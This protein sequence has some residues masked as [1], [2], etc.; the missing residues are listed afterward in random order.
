MNSAEKH[1]AILERMDGMIRRGQTG[2]AEE[3]ADKLGIKKT[4]FFNK[5]QILKE[6][7]GTISFSHPE[8]SYIYEEDAPILNFKIGRLSKEYLES[9]LKKITYR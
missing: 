1:L 9:L 5:L 2:N 4:C 6:M 7:G 8:N 3:F